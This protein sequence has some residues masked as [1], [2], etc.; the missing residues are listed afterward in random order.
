MLKLY[1]IAITKLHNSNQMYKMKSEIK[2][3]KIMYKNMIFKEYTNE[4]EKFAK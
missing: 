2:I 3:K 4:L 1:R